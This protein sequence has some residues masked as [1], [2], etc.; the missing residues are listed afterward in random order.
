MVKE[1]ILEILEL[2]D[3]YKITEENQRII[4]EE[5][6]HLNFTFGA[7]DPSHR[8]KTL[9]VFGVGL[10]LRICEEYHIRININTIIKDPWKLP[11]YEELINEVVTIQKYSNVFTR[12]KVR[13]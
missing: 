2:F 3:Q 13:K 8:N 1:E 10:L 7:P 11:E 5:G 6:L 4:I 12:K 9:N